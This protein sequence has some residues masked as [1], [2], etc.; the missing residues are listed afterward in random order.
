M[1][2][3]A[4]KLLQPRYILRYRDEVLNGD[5]HAKRMQPVG[6]AV[7]GVLVSIL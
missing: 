6:G 1:N 5:V 4:T 2:Q 3:K 7:I